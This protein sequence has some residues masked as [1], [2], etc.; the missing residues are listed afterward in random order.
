MPLRKYRAVNTGFAKIE[1][2]SRVN[3]VCMVFSASAV[4]AITD[5]LA[6]RQLVCSAAQGKRDKHSEENKL[7][8]D[9]L[10]TTRSGVSIAGVRDLRYIV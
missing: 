6:E 7:M 9:V 8:Q 1:V 2:R 10:F 4:P 3:S 5:R